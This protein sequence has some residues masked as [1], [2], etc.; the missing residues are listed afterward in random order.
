LQ[1]TRRIPAGC[2]TGNTP[3]QLCLNN[4]F[5]K[6]GFHHLWHIPI[7]RNPNA[8]PELPAGA[9]WPYDLAVPRYRL[10]R[11]TLR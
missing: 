6:T 11:S 2:G 1:R 8:P 7:A 5:W 10:I 9:L 3:S 4:S